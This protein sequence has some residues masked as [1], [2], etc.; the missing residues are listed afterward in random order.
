MS[1]IN[2]HYPLLVTNVVKAFA[3]ESNVLTDINVR[4]EHAKKAIYEIIEEGCF[5]EIVVVDGSNVSLLSDEEIRNIE[6]RGISVEQFSFLQDKDAVIKFGK[7]NGELQIINYAIENSELIKKAG[8]FFKIS[9]RY[10]I[11]NMRQILNES[12]MYETF[13]FR[14]NPNFFPKKKTLCLHNI[15]QSVSK[16]LFKKFTDSVI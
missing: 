16:F 15:L 7:S 12:Q 2:H 9:G 3:T 5:S 14:Y 6:I 11:V 4:L 13:F 10:G 8:G 1:K